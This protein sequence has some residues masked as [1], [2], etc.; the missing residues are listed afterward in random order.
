M[1]LRV[2]R[3][4]LAVAREQSITGAAESLHVTQP[5][6]S[7]QLMDLEDELGKKLFIRG[8]RKITLTDDGIYL[9]KRAQEIVDLTDKT[10]AEF[11]LSD[12][13]ITGDINIGA[14]ETESMRIV[15]SVIAKLQLKYPR[16]TFSFLKW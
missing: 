16:N 12:E 7:K 9:R 3:Y 10:E 2:L 15:I 14:G 8:N 5:T 4:F 13:I 6:L 11:H 1:E